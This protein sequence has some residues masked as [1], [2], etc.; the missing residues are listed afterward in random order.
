[1]P[2]LQN[3]RHEKFAQLV[4]VGVSLIDA[5]GKAGF[6]ENAGSASRLQKSAKVHARIEELSS[7]VHE[8]LAHRAALNRDWV[9]GAMQEV[10][11]RCMSADN[12]QPAPA[13]RALELLGKDLGLF[14]DAIDHNFKWDG[15]LSKLTESQKT[16][17]ALSLEQVAFK[18][19]PQGL[20]AWRAESAKLI[21]TTSERIPD[22]HEENQFAGQV[23]PDRSVPQ[24]GPARDTADPGKRIIDLPSL[25]PSNG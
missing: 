24:A 20:A 9:L 22:P 23:G 8:K 15:D 14:R 7:K 11:L 3:V 25:S 17:L 5:Y 2:V 21:E 10:A 1:M 19:N 4:S 12:F 6:T 18:D 16:Q 13:I